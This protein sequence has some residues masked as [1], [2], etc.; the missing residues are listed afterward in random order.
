MNRPDLPDRMLVGIVGAAALAVV[1]PIE[2]RFAGTIA[3]TAPSPAHQV[4]LDLAEDAA[5]CFTMEPPAYRVHAW[6][7]ETGV[8]SHTAF[9]GRYAGP[10]PFH[11]NGRLID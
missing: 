8:I 7:P 4:T 11:D 10:Y 3:S 9:V 5:S 1:R 2:A 6:T